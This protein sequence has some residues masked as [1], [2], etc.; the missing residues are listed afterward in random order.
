[1][2]EM[3]RFNAQIHCFINNQNR[4]PRSSAPPSAKVVVATVTYYLLAL[5]FF[6]LVL[7][8]GVPSACFCKPCYLSV[9]SVNAGLT[10]DHLGG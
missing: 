5:V 1:M 2:G 6:D 4:Y 7:L 3:H 9:Q 8:P 10:L